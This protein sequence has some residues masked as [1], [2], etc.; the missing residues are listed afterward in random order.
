MHIRPTIGAYYRAPLPVSPLS[1]N[2]LVS[3]VP[4]FV[5]SITNVVP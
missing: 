2:K 5:G 1:T 3:R 4:G